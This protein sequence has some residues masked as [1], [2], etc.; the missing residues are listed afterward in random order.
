[1]RKAV[2]ENGVVSYV[3]EASE[4]FTIEGKTLI[5]ANDNVAR[6]DLWDGSSFSRPAAGEPP[7][8]AMYASE[9]QLLFTNDELASIQL[10]VDQNVIRLRTWVQTIIDPVLGDDARVT[11]G[12]GY[13]AYIGLLTADRAARILS[14][15]APEVT[16]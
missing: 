8:W 3:I 14:G 9:F 5:A 12:I 4:S 15:L 11:G 7:A 13:L 2:V 16:P 6:G 1:M 10:S